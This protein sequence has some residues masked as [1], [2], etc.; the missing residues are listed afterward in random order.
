MYHYQDGMRRYNHW[1]HLSAMLWRDFRSLVDE[2]SPVHSI[3][4]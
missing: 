4:F 2:F 1:F 3:K